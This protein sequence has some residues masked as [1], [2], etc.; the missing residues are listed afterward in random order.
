[1]RSQRNSIPIPS[2]VAGKPGQ[3]QNQVY[4]LPD[5]DLYGVGDEKYKFV[6]QN[7]KLALHKVVDGGVDRKNWI[8]SDLVW[9][10][11]EDGWYAGTEALESREISGK[12]IE[13]K[14]IGLL[15]NKVGDWRLLK[16]TKLPLFLAY[17]ATQGATHACTTLVED[18]EAYYF[19]QGFSYNDKSQFWERSLPK[20][21]I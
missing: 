3:K 20:V 18:M 15:Q 16:W 6:R 14:A 19:S 5:E 7:D 9:V 17:L 2:I 13:V 21:E 8:A 11:E 4:Y 10:K 12:K 1:M